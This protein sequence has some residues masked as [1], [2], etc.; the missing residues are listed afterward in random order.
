MIA[1]ARPGFLLR[2]SF[3]AR[4]KQTELAA[5]VKGLVKRNKQTIV[6]FRQL[7]ERQLLAQAQESLDRHN[8]GYSTGFRGSMDRLRHVA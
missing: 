2:L 3:M 4:T 6:S 5:M 1:H 8:Q 7:Q